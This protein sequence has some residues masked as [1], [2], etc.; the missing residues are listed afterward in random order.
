MINF[1]ESKKIL[2]CLWL[3][4]DLSHDGEEDKMVDAS[5]DFSGKGRILS[6]IDDLK[7]HHR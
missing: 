4:S 1:D 6:C 3:E 5:R 2:S 7:K